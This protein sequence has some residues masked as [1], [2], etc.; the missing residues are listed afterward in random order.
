MVGMVGCPCRPF[1]GAS[2]LPQVILQVI[3]A[4]NQAG[5]GRCWKGAAVQVIPTEASPEPALSLPGCCR[6]T[7]GWCRSAASGQMPNLVPRSPTGAA[8]PSR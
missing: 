8:T 4:A 5:I 2:L 1:R 3:Q 7:P 6:A